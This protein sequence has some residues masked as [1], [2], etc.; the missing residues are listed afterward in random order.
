MHQVISELL[1]WRSELQEQYRNPLFEV[2]VLTLNLGH[3]HGGDNPNRICAE[4][5]LQIDIRPLPGME[6]EQ[7]RGELSLRLE[8]RLKGT[9]LALE[10]TWH[11]SHG[12]AGHCRDRTDQ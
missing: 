3:I 1:T 7:L 5:E 6:L 4:C 9:G 2:E 10:M 11:S 8:E 12:D